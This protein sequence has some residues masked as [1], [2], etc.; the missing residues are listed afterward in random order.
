[1]RFQYEEGR[2][3]RDPVMPSYWIA[4]PTDRGFIS[5]LSPEGVGQLLMNAE[6]WPAGRYT[7]RVHRHASFSTG[8]NE[9]CWGYAEKGGDGK[10]WIE[11]SDEA[12]GIPQG[13]TD[14]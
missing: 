14:L 7:I 4:H 10:V 9:L 2:W 5:A 13:L 12:M 6:Q 11:P 1:M 3:H 8:Q